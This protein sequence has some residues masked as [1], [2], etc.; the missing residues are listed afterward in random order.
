MALSD[1]KLVQRTLAGDREAFGDLVE[2]HRRTVFALAVQRGFQPAE[3]DDVAQEVFLKAFR[4]L[5]TL[6]KPSHFARWIY[7][8]A[9]HVSADWVRRRRRLRELPRLTRKGE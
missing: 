2:R 4:N 5:E 3:A 7:G 6:Q 8:I 9:A 1:A